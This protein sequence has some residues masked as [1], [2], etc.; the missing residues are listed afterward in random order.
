MLRNRILGIALAVGITTLAHLFSSVLPTLG[1]ALLALVLGVLLRQVITRFEPFSAGVVWTEKYV[2]ETAIVFIGFGFEIR[3]FS[4]IGFSTVLVILLSIIAVLLFSLL[5]R[6]LFKSEDSNVFWLLGIGSAICGSSAIGATAPIIRAKQEETGISMTV[7]N[8]LGLC[9]MIL[10]PLLASAL[11][12]SHL[13]TGI[14]L[15]GILQSVGHVVGASF[16]INPEVGE[17]ATL[18]KMCRV[19]FL[20][21]FLLVLYYIF[22]KNNDGTKIKFP[23][24]I[25]FFLLAVVLSQVDIFNASGLKFL[26]KSGDVMLNVAMAAIGLKIN[27]KSL[28][29]I[30]G[31]AFKVGLAIFLLQILIFTVYLL[32]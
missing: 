11:S 14:Y 27:L 18:V 2:L 1:T 16:A 4:H 23:L 21:P 26:S 15:G 31:K 5:L 10:L 13:Q 22:R 9:G 24:F 19:A 7:I 30:S 28:W 32:F 20:A 12:L 29:S 3:K 17:F 25:I 8:L 6:K